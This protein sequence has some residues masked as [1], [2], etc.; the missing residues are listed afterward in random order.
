M[1][2]YTGAEWNLYRHRLVQV[3]WLRSVCLCCPRRMHVTQQSS[4]LFLTPGYCWE[5]M[6]SQIRHMDEERGP[7]SKRHRPQECHHQ[8]Q[9]RAPAVRHDSTGGRVGADNQIPT[10]QAKIAPV[11]PACRVSHEGNRQSSVLLV[12]LWLFCLLR[13]V[14]QSLG[15]EY[16]GVGNP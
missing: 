2:N 13:Q 9:L 4:I 15:A 5:H 3:S 1:V 11:A 12:G 16:G 10:P 14:V 7:H 6:T 8:L